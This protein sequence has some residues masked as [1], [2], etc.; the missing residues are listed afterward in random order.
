[1]YELIIVGGGPAGLT[2][3]IYAKRAGIDALL[4]ERGAIGGQAILTNFIENYP[5]YT[6][7]S[8]IELMQKFEEQARKLGLE[9]K[10]SEVTHIEVG[11]KKIVKT[12]DG[13]YEAITVI[14][15]T[16]TNQKKLGVEG[17][18]KFFG[19]GVSYCATCD[20]PF[21][22]NKNVLVVGGGDAAIT[23]AI[24][25]TKFA[26][27]VYVVHR[28]DKLRATKIL[29]DRALANEKIEM[30]WNSVVKEIIGKEKI[31]K[32]VLENL[33]EKKIYEMGIDGIFIFVGSEPNTSFINVK[34]DKEGYII[35]DEYMKTSAKGIYAAG[36][37]RAK[38]LRQISTAV[39]DGAIAAISAEK[40]INQGERNKLCW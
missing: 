28:R 27:K 1:M 11:N 34:K 26:K 16:G 25:L 29:A 38:F 21:F 22:K 20:A 24:F 10:T 32:V 12:T 9:F 15:A 19:K 14:V 8:G 31:E 30:I 3:G 23:E 4:I 39:G 5:G 37:C 35:T 6:G 33:A 7:I 17:E 40:H 13:K 18:E 36:D 2:A